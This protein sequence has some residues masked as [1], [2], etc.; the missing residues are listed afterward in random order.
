V[1]QVY[2][3]L[4]Y[5][6]FNRS[7][8][9]NIQGFKCY[10]YEPLDPDLLPPVYLAYHDSL[11]EP[12]EVFHN[13]IRGRFDRGDPAVVNAMQKF[14]AIAEQ[15]RPALLQKDASRLA[16]LIDENFN[17]RRGIYNLAPWQVRMVEAARACGASAKFAGSGG[18]IIGTY[19]DESMYHDIQKALEPIGAKTIKPLVKPGA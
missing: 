15:G 10:A 18:A 4:V 5:M 14:A 3:G 6:D 7:Q 19:R 1:I 11:S 8:E 13:D 16:A 12:T 17:T 9:Q 2:E